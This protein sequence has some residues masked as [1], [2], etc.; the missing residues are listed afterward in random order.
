MTSRERRAKVAKDTLEII[1]QG[2]YYNNNNSWVDI[3]EFIQ[4]SIANTEL[5]SPH[6]LQSIEKKIIEQNL[7]HKEDDFYPIEVTTEDTLAAANRLYVNGY[8]PVCL[9]FASAINPGGG[10]LNGNSA[11]EESLCRVSSLYSSINSKKEFYVANKAFSSALYTDYMIYSP[12][13]PVFRDINDTLLDKPF[14]TSFITAPAVNAKIV[15]TQ[16]PEN[17]NLIEIIMRSRISKIIS[18]ASFLGHDSIVLGA[19]GCGVFEN[20]VN[21]VARYFEE[22]LKNK[23]IL[24]NKIVFAILGDSN[25]PTY[26]IFKKT[27]LN[28]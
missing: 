4:R 20:D 6:K 22:N 8:N 7:I 2:G 14:Y 23:A 5:F 15:T 3:K 18:L 17:I 28:S 26:K 10:F 11:Q 24:F 1:D 25:N 19:F 12:E 21:D 9:N 27:L 13:V 16:E